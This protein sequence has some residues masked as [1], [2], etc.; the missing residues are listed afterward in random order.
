M[1]SQPLARTW[2]GRCGP[3]QAP[4][5]WAS[6]RAFRF[7]AVPISPVRVSSSARRTTPVHNARECR[8]SSAAFSRIR[9][10]GVAT[11]LASPGPAVLSADAS[12]RRRGWLATPHGSSHE[13]DPGRWRGRASRFA[14]VIRLLCRGFLWHAQVVGPAAGYAVAATSVPPSLVLHDFYRLT[15]GLHVLILSWPILAL[16]RLGR[17]ALRRTAPGASEPGVGADRRSRSMRR[18]L[19]P[20]SRAPARRCR[21]DRPVGPGTPGPGL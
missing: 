17:T 2:L 15:A 1:D 5:A 11:A 21:S 7:A 13:S 8:H 10:S 4:R 20:H 18:R 9:A 16:P 6:S 3:S 14:R 19:V 12:P